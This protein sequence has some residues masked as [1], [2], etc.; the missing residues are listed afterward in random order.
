M[1]EFLRRALGASGSKGASFPRTCNVCGYHGRFQSGGK[2]RRIDARCPKCGS[3]ERYRLLALWLDGHGAFLRNAHVLHFAPEAGL[4]AMLKK[5]VGRYESADIAP[6]RADRVL[7]IEAIAMPDASY[8]CVLCSHVLEHVDD[9]KALSEIFRVLKPGGVAL[10]MLP[11]IEGWAHTYENPQ[12]T[13]PE[14]RKRH[15]GQADHVRYYGADVRER[16]GAAGFALEEF[17]AEGPDVLT[18]ALQ[19]GEKVFI[20]TKRA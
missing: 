17:T 10:I 5:R 9:A 6:G 19:R 12:V 2:P 7:N 15:Y 3:A 11:V 14:E 13:T 8:D 18:Y 16:I 20:A 4:A 1:M